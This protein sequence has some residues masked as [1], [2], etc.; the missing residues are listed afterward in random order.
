MSQCPKIPARILFLVPRMPVG[1]A[2]TFLI[3]ILRRIDKN[4]AQPIVFSM[5]TESD[6]MF[7]KIPNEIPRYIHARKWRYDLSP[8]ASIEKIIIDEKIQTVVCA[9][10]F[11][12]FYFR[13]ATRKGNVH[14]RVVT[15]L[16][17]TK[18]RDI[19]EFL[20]GFI[21][22][23]L[24]RQNDEVLTTCENQKQYLSRLFKIP[25]NRFAKIIYNGIDTEY[26][27]LPADP[28]IRNAQRLRFG[29]PENAVVIVNVAGFR[30]EKR[31]DIMLQALAKIRRETSEREYYL[32]F[33]GGG[34]KEL[35]VQSENL[36]RELKIAD[37]VVFAG[38]QDDLRLMYWMAD[39]FTL[40]STSETFSIAALEAMASG[41]PC[42][43]TD[44]GGANEM[45]TENINGV[46]V[47]AGSPQSLAE[48]WVR[49][50]AMLNSLDNRKI[51]KSVTDR[52]TL[53]ECVSNYEHYF[54]GKG[55]N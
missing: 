48:G 44:V 19:K 37:R 24:L 46:I 15:L 52:F 51:R 5:G 42:V 10:Y 16:H 55:G 4:V 53:Q 23:R 20:H 27:N 17:V 13:Y 47:N 6:P 43:L 40:G 32:L 29:I 9:D 49:C 45:I 2:E 34:S 50:A 28:V 36:A 14:V 3:S 31:H 41:L 1:G 26:W 7:L 12:Y 54:S 8:C 30:A 21:F 35:R 18:P 38:I 39:M 11:T 25:E 33:V 22:A